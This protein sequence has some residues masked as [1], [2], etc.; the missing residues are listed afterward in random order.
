[1]KKGFTLIELLVVVL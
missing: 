1:M